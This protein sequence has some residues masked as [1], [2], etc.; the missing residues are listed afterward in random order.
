MG[1]FRG[2]TAWT[3]DGADRRD[4]ALELGSR[5]RWIAYLMPQCTLRSRGQGRL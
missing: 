4:A 2:T 3:E 1:P 5:Q